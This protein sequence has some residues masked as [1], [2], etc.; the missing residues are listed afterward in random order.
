MQIALVFSFIFGY[1]V[2]IFE[3]LVKVNKSAIALMI[4]VLSWGIVFAVAPDAA[5]H[6]ERHLAEISQIIFFLFGAMAIVELIDSH[7]GFALITQ[8]IQSP[9]KVK[10][11]WT[12]SLLTFFMSSVLDNL[13]TTIVMVSLLRKL[14]HGQHDRW[15][16]GS[17]V[18]IAANAG[19]AWTPIGDV[20]TTMLWINGQ[21]SAWPIMKMLFLPSLASLVVSILFQMFLYRGRQV[22]FANLT[23][24]V[25][26]EPYGTAIFFLGLSVLAGVPLLKVLFH[27]PPFMGIL[28]GLGFLW[29]VT[30]LAHHDHKNRNH[31]RLNSIFQRV[32]VSSVLFFLGI[33]LSISALESAGILKNFAAYVNIF[34]PSEKIIAATIGIASSIV[35]NVPLVAACMGMYDLQTYAMDCSFW[36]MIAYCAGTGGSILIIG[37]AAGVALMGMESVDFFW[38]VKNVS[39]TALVGYLVGF[40]IYLILNMV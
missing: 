40:G 7:K 8:L 17:L 18:V 34:L 6:L 31:L 13:T 22:E 19:G 12:I 15:I 5:H 23:I 35:D 14:I 28:I 9:S 36:Q 32:D 24:P 27:I 33:L 11:M 29:L 21:V 3:H 30:D 1:F 26:P 39:L 16:F 25:E 10:M 20:T 38:Y 37:S 2:I 4:A